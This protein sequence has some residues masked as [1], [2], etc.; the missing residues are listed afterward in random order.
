[1]NDYFQIAVDGPVA[2][3]KGTIC[4][5]VA[6]RLDMLYV[7]TGAMYRVAAL[8]AKRHNLKY[9]DQDKILPLLKKSKIELHK[10]TIQ[11]KDGRLVTVLLD[12]EDVS[13]EIRTPE[14]SQ[15]VPVVS[16]LKKV[17]EILVQKQQEIA[18]DQDVVMEGRDITYRVLPDANLK[19]FLTAADFVRARRRHLDL[20]SKGEDVT[21]DQVYKALVERDQLDSTRAVD[22]LMIV[23]DAWVVDTSDLSIEKV[24]S[25]I[26]ERV[27]GIR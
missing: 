27:G 17:R 24:V 2:A 8:I 14:I 12:G 4:R 1:M 21:Y 3:G 9:S 11:E 5:L 18:E 19:I 26:V 20:L 23:E 6:E 25:M 15:A 10:P 16:Q 7:D 22:P 13:W